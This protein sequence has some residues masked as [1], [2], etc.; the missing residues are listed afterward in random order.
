MIQILLLHTLVE[1]WKLQT[2]H[3]HGHSRTR[4]CLK[5][6]RPL[7]P[8]VFFPLLITWEW[9]VQILQYK[10]HNRSS[11]C[12]GL[13]KWHGTQFKQRW[14]DELACSRLYLTNIACYRFSSLQVCFGS[15]FQENTIVILATGYCLVTYT[16]KD[17]VLWPV[18]D[19]S[20]VH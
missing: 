11:C 4:F 6:F 7:M 15:A 14:F 2:M 3:F 20:Q 19:Y 13:P 10:M 18:N 9:R 16:W 17:M 1:V 5:S 8:L 12:S